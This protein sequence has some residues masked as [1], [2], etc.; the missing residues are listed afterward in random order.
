MHEAGSRVD[1]QPDGVVVFRGPRGRLN[2]AEAR[3]PRLAG[4]GHAALE[5]A[6]GAAGIAIDRRTS[7]PRWDGS[8][9]RLGWAV[10][11]LAGRQARLT[12]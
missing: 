3:R 5:R 10:E 1:R 8:P 7:L 9:L 12:G 4:D 6:Q 2:E 11:A